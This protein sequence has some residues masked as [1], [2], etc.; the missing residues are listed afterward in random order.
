M[1][2]TL[3]IAITISR[4]LGCGGGQIAHAVASR[5]GYHLADREILEKAAAEFRAPPEDLEP[6]EETIRSGW[7]PAFNFG[8]FTPDFFAPTTIPMAPVDFLPTTSEL[9]EVEAAIIAKLASEGSSVILGRCGFHV[10]REHPRHVAIALHADRA[11]RIR[12]IQQRHGLD[13]EVARERV[14][15][16]DRAR[17]EY[18]LE[19]TDR[20]AFDARA[21]DLC[22]ETSRF[23]LDRCVDLITA[24]VQARFP[25]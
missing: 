5:L 20:H 6:C 3:P 11:S 8:A 12:C 22:L 15:T 10:L 25:A 18:I 4:Q 19:C 17:S 1:D 7:N 23:G 2:S 14:E 24:F 21:F 13:E 9:F 16:N